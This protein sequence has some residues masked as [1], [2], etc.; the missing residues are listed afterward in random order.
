M[1]RIGMIGE[2]TRLEVERR[3]KGRGRRGKVREEG[4][5]GAL[6]KKRLSRTTHSFS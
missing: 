4:M 3:R 2:E 5:G 6:Q 1:S